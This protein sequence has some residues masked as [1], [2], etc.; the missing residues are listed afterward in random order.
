MDGSQERE[1]SVPA[2]LRTL[3]ESA[4]SA[5]QSDPRAPLVPPRDKPEVHFAGL[6]IT[7]RIGG[8]FPLSPGQKSLWFMQQIL[9]ESA[10]YHIALCVRILSPLDFSALQTA[11][12]A[13]VD[14]HDSLRTVFGID[15]NGELLQKTQA[16]GPVAFEVI[17]TSGLSRDEIDALVT[18]AFRQ[19]FDLAAGPLFRS[20]LVYGPERK[21]ISC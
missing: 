5:L 17:D 16:R 12:Q 15:G 11:L 19:P 1:I 21:I 20:H 4:Q 13:I 2:K 8:A 7:D 10:V 14:R 3:S 18:A 9:P 6:P